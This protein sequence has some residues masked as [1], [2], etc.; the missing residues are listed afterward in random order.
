MKLTP[1][2]NRYISGKSPSHSRSG[3]LG[4]HFEGLDVGLVTQLLVALGALSG[5]KPTKRAVQ[6]GLID[7]CGTEIL[8]NLSKLELALNS[9]GMKTTRKFA[10]QRLPEI[11]DLH[12]SLSSIAAYFD[13]SPSTVGKWLKDLG[14]REPNGAP[15][16]KL[17]KSGKAIKVEFKDGNKKREYFKWSLLWT[18]S[19][20]QEAGH[21]FDF[22]FEKSLKGK[23]KNSDVEINTL[24]G[25][26][27]E[28]AKEFV[29]LY[30]NKATRNEAKRL[31]E[32]QPP[33]LVSKVEEILGRPGWISSGKYLGK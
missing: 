14:F 24:D 7:V 23:G 16:K 12:V 25:R 13:E 3:N 26:A 32:R 20:L 22:D 18:L 33:I 31:I 11:E 6:S 10:N 8:W 28:L 30:N 17:L 19:V 29:A 1:P 27:K 5:G 4:E 9:A 15:I 2:I 21:P